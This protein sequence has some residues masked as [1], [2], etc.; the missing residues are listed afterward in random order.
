M[1]NTRQAIS[2]SIIILSAVFLVISLAGIFLTW[3]FYQRLNDDLIGRLEAIEVDLRSAQGDL[4]VVQTELDAVQEQIDALQ[5]ALQTLGV[6]GSASLEAV[7]ELIARLENTLTPFITGVAER[8]EDLRNAVVRLK[9]TIERLNELPLVNLTIPGVEQLEE[10]VASLENLQSDIEQ[11]RDQVSEASQITQDTIDTL[12]TGFTDL[13]ASVQTLSAALQRYDAMISG[14]LEELD[15]L[16]ANIPRWSII[17][18]ISLA[19]IFVWLGFS[20]VALFV[21]AWSFYR[22]EDLTA[23]WRV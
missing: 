23:R 4:Q 16:Q 19:V 6:D 7:A 13:E 1:K 2:L 21:L 14:Y 11:G 18:A 12:N 17:A 20:Q 5:A 22:G 8:V 10:A 9:E 3:S 15:V